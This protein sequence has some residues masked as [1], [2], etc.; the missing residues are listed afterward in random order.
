MCRVVHVYVVRL[1]VTS[2]SF[3][4]VAPVLHQTWAKMSSNVAA[5]FIRKMSSFRGLKLHNPVKPPGK[6]HFKN[7]I[8][9]VYCID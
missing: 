7:I 8:G 9:V 6:P 3:L 4:A 2:F 1:A 5:M